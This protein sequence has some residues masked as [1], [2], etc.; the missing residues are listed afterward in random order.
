MSTFRYQSQDP[1]QGPR[2]GASND[3]LPDEIKSNVVMAGRS[4]LLQ[5]E[6]IAAIGDE[7]SRRTGMPMTQ[8]DFMS[9]IGHIKRLDG[10]RFATMP[11]DEAVDTIVTG[12]L[13]YSSRRDDTIIDTHEVMKQYLGGGVKV[14]PSLFLLPKNA[15]TSNGLEPNLASVRQTA[16]INAY[17]MDPRL[18]GFTSGA[19][20]PTDVQFPP[21]TQDEEEYLTTKLD[22]GD[23][24]SGVPLQGTY[25]RKGNTIKPREKST[26][27]LLD[28]RYR[29]RAAGS[30]SFIW[31]VTAVP[32]N[33]NGAVAAQ[34]GMANI[35]YMTT[36][37]FY[38][39]YIPEADTPSK[40][41]SLLIEELGMA[42]VIAHENRNYHFL[43]NTTIDNNRILLT[44]V[45][46]RF[47]F[48]EPIDRVNRITITFG[49]P[50][51]Q[52]HFLPDDYPV[53]ITYNGPNSTYINFLV[54]HFMADGEVV[55]ITGFTTA[56]P[57]RDFAVINE[58]NSQ[59]GVSV[60]VV[61]D[62]T[63]EITPDLTGATLITPPPSVDLYITT[64]R[65]Q[66]PLRF[67]QIQ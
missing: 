55:L 62:T 29:V 28:S 1:R 58:I 6:V 41:V 10:N 45:Y 67:A 4:R 17:A 12:Y 3:R 5:Q 8:V 7:L 23:E 52:L 54:P 9:L 63:L 47:S 57:A 42:A 60:N 34:A 50:L 37:A 20:G 33:S 31:G 64:R 32:T 35:V 15:G 48:N 46:D 30:S 11:I 56:N 18:D 51:T 40:Q 65:I 19:A 27:F 53:T 2:V 24:L 36:E 61:N 59:Y 44:P 16:H 14:S 43:F 66:I 25:V 21:R 38:I 13:T 26:Y 22:R 39:P 49:N